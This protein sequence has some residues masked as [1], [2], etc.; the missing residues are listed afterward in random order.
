M[1]KC[2]RIRDSVADACAA[3][4]WIEANRH[5]FKAAI[6]VP[7]TERMTDTKLTRWISQ[8]SE[9]VLFEQL[10]DSTLFDFADVADIK[11]F[12]VLVNGGLGLAAN[13]CL[14]GQEYI[15]DNTLD[16]F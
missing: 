6:T 8:S 13:I 14:N 11:L 10:R 5:V 12:I 1:H 15:A 3:A 4:Q 9:D 2:Q 7:R 16:L